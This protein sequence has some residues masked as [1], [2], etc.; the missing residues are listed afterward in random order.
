MPEHIWL[1]PAPARGGV[2]RPAE[3]SRAQ[4]VD[5][6]LAVADCEGL[7][8]VTTRR[9]ARELGTGP[10]SLYRHV[11]TRADM[12]DLMVDAA[13]GEYETPAVTGDWRADVVAEHLHR[14]RYLRSRPWI[15]DA[16]QERP[17]IGPAA[18]LLL[19]HTLDQLR[20]HPCSGRAKLEAVGT[21]SG[22]IQ[23]YLR[24]ER[25]GKGVLDTEFVRA[26][27]ELFIRAAR[28]GTHPRL[29]D[30]MA[31]AAP[32]SDESDDDQLARVF[33]L[34]LDGLLGPRPS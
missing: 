10:A 19:E 24:N 28:D 21:L 2:G 17:H 23:T 34:V 11:A 32:T 22:M 5:V 1:R 29:A 14:V 33:G 13:L 15:I 9:V 8:A 30:V 26:R 20:D 25:P 27:T 31:E 16:A 3:W 18:I 4:I 6:A 12:I 7:A